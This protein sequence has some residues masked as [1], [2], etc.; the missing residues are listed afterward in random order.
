[1]KHSVTKSYH[2]RLDAERVV[3][4]I[5]KMRVE[6]NNGKRNAGIVP[7]RYDNKLGS[8]ENLVDRWSRWIPSVVK[9]CRRCFNYRKNLL[10]KLNFLADW[11]FRNWTKCLVFPSTMVLTFRELP[12]RFF[13]RKIKRDINFL[14]VCLAMV[15]KFCKTT[16]SVAN[17]YLRL[18]CDIRRKKK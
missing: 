5:G 9:V 3:H 7:R 13:A 1:M 15:E 12:R 18:R 8:I 10:M 6:I 4:Q 17:E 2:F 16:V 14:S 11:F